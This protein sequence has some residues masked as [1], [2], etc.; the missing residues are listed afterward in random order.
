MDH[1][2]EA[3]NNPI[4]LCSK[5][6]HC[7]RLLYLG[8]DK[9]FLVASLP[10]G[11]ILKTRN[12]SGG[13]GQI[14]GLGRS[15][16]F[17]LAGG[18][19]F[20]FESRTKVIIWD[21]EIGKRVSTISFHESLKVSEINGLDITKDYLIVALEN[22]LMLYKVANQF[23]PFQKLNT[24]PNQRGVFSISVKDNETLL[25][26]PYLRAEKDKEMG[27]L[28]ILNISKPDQITHIHAHSDQIWQIEFSRTGKYIATCSRVGSI[29]RIWETET[30]HMATEIRRG[31][32]KTNLHALRFDD[33][34]HWLI[35]CNDGRA[36]NI[37]DLNKK[38]K[39]DESGEKYSPLDENWL[40]RFIK[41]VTQ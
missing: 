3:T 12:F 35:C 21:E 29:I 38:L 28:A 14:A 40:R 15:N 37:Y 8:M 34:D 11:D 19:R 5:I 32:E 4:V 31:Y 6:S 20:P 18:G 24:I 17:A 22:F 39:T 36:I 26:Y 25:A 9:G 2:E 33:K 13:V 30:G 10:K 23:Q 7:G 1:M 41:W 16:I 27:N